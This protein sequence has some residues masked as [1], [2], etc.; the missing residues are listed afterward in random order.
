[1]AGLKK[2]NK[3]CPEFTDHQ[4]LILKTWA[5][6]P[7]I[8]Q[9]AAELNL[10]ENTVQTHLRRMRSKLGVSRTFDVWQHVKEQGLL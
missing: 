1:M 5:E 4:L 3:K 9:V 2:K 6:Q 7:S 8:G 10:A